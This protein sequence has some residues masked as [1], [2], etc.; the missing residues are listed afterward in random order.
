M[1]GHQGRVDKP[2]RRIHQRD[3]RRMR[4]AYPPYRKAL[5]LWR[6]HSHRRSNQ[7]PLPEGRIGLRPRWLMRGHQGRVDK[8]ARRIHQRDVRRMR[9]AYPPYRKALRLWRLHSHRRRNHFPLPEGRVGLRPR[10]VMRGHQGRVDKPT[11]RI[12]QRD[13][14][15]MRCAYPPYRK[16]FRLWRLHSHRRRNHFPLPEGRVGL[17]PRWVMRG[18]QGRVDKPARR[19]HQ[20][21][22]RRMRCAYPPYR[23]ALRLW[24]NISIS[25]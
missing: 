4:C 11:R 12:H 14:R 20:R 2:A 13:V 25:R 3:V 5:R 21:D 9:C 1:R 16:A 22:V 8:P 7:L 10:W 23:K 17:R 18:Y 6:L 24:L 15:R 19:I